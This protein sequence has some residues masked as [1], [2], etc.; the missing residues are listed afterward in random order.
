MRLVKKLLQCKKSKNHTSLYEIYQK[1]NSNNAVLWLT[2]ASFYSLG[3]SNFL[4]QKVSGTANIFIENQPK[5][6]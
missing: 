6:S 2:M 5:Y 1:L 3:T 4:Y